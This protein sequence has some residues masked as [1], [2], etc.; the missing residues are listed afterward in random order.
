MEQ[1]SF[2]Q[3]EKTLKDKITKQM[4]TALKKGIMPGA[5]VYFDEDKSSLKP[6]Q[7]SFIEL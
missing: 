5:L 7:L 4:K 6:Y 2:I 1:L 3:S